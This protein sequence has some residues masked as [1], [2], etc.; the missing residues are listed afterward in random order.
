MTTPGVESARVEKRLLGRS[1]WDPQVLS[2]P[3]ALADATYPPTLGLWSRRPFVMRGFLDQ[4]GCHGKRVLL[5]YVQ[6]RSPRV[7]RR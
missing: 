7:G 3:M 2:S 6:P 5:F 1:D 4:K